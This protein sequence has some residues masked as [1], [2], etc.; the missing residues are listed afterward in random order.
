MQ[1]VVVL[2]DDELHQALGDEFGDHPVGDGGLH[3]L[4]V[5]P[6]LRLPPFF[7]TRPQPVGSAEIGQSGAGGDAG[8]G[9]HHDVLGLPDQLAD[10]VHLHLRDCRRV[11]FNYFDLFCDCRRVRSV[12]DLLGFCQQVIQ[13][14]VFDV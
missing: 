12:F 8:A 1:V 5:H 7:L 6:L 14:V 13:T 10:F 11:H 4:H 3:V 2:R 9:E